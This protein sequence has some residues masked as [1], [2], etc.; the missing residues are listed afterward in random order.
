M[1][2][3]MTIRAFR[4]LE[5][6]IATVDTCRRCR[7]VVLFGLA[8][9]LPARAELRSLDTLRDE[10]RAVLA[11]RQTYTLTRAGLVH[12]DAGRRSD[13]TLAGPVLAEHACPERTAR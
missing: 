8:E 5:T 3:R 12:R 1:A 11:G 6:T 13:P 9:G 10:P 4:H 7:A 2:G